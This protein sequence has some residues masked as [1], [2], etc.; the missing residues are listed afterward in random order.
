LREDVRKSLREVQLEISIQLIEVKVVEK[1]RL[2]FGN[3]IC[4]LEQNRDDGLSHSV[5]ELSVAS[6]NL[7]DELH[8]HAIANVIELVLGWPPEYHLSAQV[9]KVVAA[10]IGRGQ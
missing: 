8:F 2:T 4:N 7:M 6:L 3:V 5:R 10:D 9:A 1:K